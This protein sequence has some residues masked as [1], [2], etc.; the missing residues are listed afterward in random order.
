MCSIHFIG[1]TSEQDIVAGLML[2]SLL[3]VGSVDWADR[4]MARISF[5]GRETGDVYVVECRM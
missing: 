1:Q 5:K 4:H 2:R 3:I